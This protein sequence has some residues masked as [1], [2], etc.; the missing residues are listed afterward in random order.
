LSIDGQKYE[1][2]A[3]GFENVVAMDVDIADNKLYLMDAGK[4]RLYRIGLDNLGAP[5]ADYETVVRHNIFGTEGIAVDWV[6]IEFE[7]FT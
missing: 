2:V 7:S 3:R 5:I 4:L 1:L 6:G